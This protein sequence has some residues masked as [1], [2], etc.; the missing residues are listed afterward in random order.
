VYDPVDKIPLT[1]LPTSKEAFGFLLKTPQKP[2][3]GLEKEDVTEKAA[4]H[5]AAAFRSMVE[6]KIKPQEALTY[7]LQ[8]ILAMF[9][10]DVELLP[11]KILHRI[12]D[13]LANGGGDGFEIVPLSYDLI[14]GLFCEM[15]SEGISKGFRYK[16][17]DYFNG[18]L[19]KK[20]YAI[21]LT[22]YEIECLRTAS[23]QNWQKVNPAIFGTIFEQGLE[24]NERHVLG[25]HYTSEI[26]IKKVVVP[27]LV[28]PW[29][30][31][32]ELA[33]T[34]DEYFELLN[35]IS[36][37]KILDPACGSGNFLFVAYKELKLL[38][39]QILTKIRERFVNPEEGK[40]LREFLPNYRFVSIQQFYGYDI[41]P[42]AVELAKVS[43]MVAKEL[44]YFEHKEAF[45]KKFKPLPLDNL[46][47]YIVCQDALLDE[48]DSPRQWLEAD[49]IMGNPPYQSKNKMLTEFGGEYLNKLWKAYPQMNKYGDFC[50]YWFYKA[51]ETLKE[52]GYAGLVGTN[53]I[54]EN[55]SRENSLEF[56]LN[57]N[58]VIFNAVSSQ[59]W[60]GEAA[61]YVS[62]VNWKKG[63]YKNP[64]RKLFIFNEKEQKLKEIEVSF[65]NSSL[66]LN[67]DV[68]SAKIL[69]SNKEQKLCLQG[70]THGHEG[71]LINK[72]LA[73]NWIKENSEYNEILKPFLTGDE[74]VG[75]V[76]SQPQ[77]F[78]IDFVGKDLHETKY[79]KKA[80]EHL[81]KTVFVFRQEKA[82]EQK[83]TNEVLLRKNPKSI[84]NK[85]YINIF[86][87]WWTLRREKKDLLEWLGQ[88]KKYIACSRVTL[89][90]IF[91]FVSTE[92]HP[93]DAIMAFAFEDD[94]TFG[95]I[96]SQIH[97]E[98]FKAKCSSLGETFRY[99]PSSVW[100]TFPFPQNPSE[101]QVKKVAEISKQLRDERNNLIQKFGVTFRE[102]Y[103][104]LEVYG[105]SNLKEL[106]FELDKAVFEAYEF[107]DLLHLSKKVKVSENYPHYKLTDIILADLLSLNHQIAE[108]EAKGEPVL[109]PG[110]PPYI[111]HPEKF[112]SDDCVKLIQEI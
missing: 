28:E 23:R 103:Q 52:G 19:F 60:A 95:I 9:A 38:E 32:I 57:N 73:M 112:V 68:T 8:C 6:R 86:E 16:G 48:N 64:I 81:Q 101:K 35:E 105:K 11:N 65:I 47:Q 56:I 18:G 96:Q 5:V 79:F 33:E 43:L 74:L 46:D 21:E 89:R 22:R 17:V 111:P 36:Q 58:G 62:I 76:K 106:H 34:Q 51:H 63:E 10:Q 93:N 12:F 50:T 61:V 97:W 45:D 54:R 49:V 40:K 109:A 7:C 3:F 88:H 72:T 31:K 104:T 110:L 14:K 91:E 59:E 1:Q 67:T 53:T 78:V 13:E 20:I 42:F 100:D 25:A 77:R 2:I 108:K 4:Y 71:F 92:I 69:L 87:R 90:P 44:A 29:L 24:K 39:R 107:K 27:C 15:N 30:E 99:T 102:L 98:W 66:S 37:I 83:A 41:K 70:Q 80:F 26:D 85:D 84:V 82:E 75:G 94:Y 55:N